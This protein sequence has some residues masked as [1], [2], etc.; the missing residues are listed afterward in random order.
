[1][2]SL[3]LR[4]LAVF[5]IAFYVL[6]CILFTADQSLI[7]VSAV[8]FSFLFIA[9]L[10]L[11]AF[12]PSTK[13]ISMKSA[14]IR[15]LIF[16]L[17]G[18][19]LSSLIMFYSFEIK[20]SKY[21]ELCDKEVEIEGSVTDV[22]W[23]GG[24]SG[25]YRVK[26][27]SIDS[28]SPFSCIITTEGGISENTRISSV[29]LFSPLENNGQFD[30]KS[31]YLSQNVYLKGESEKVFLLGEE[32]FTLSS[33]AGLINDSLSRIFYEY[34]G[35]EEGSFA[36]ALLLGNTSKL[37]DTVERDFKRL[38]IS[39]V[40]AISGMHLTVLCSFA[41]TLL[42]PLGKRASNAGC[43]VIVTFYMFITGFAPP[44]TR[45]GIVVLL[46]IFS[47]LIHKSSD[48]FT[49]LGISVFLICIADPFSAADIGLQL[50]FAALMAILL[51]SDKREELKSEKADLK[52]LPTS[53]IKI[54]K[55]FTSFLDEATLTAII[56]LFMLPIEWLYFKRLCPISPFI[57]PLFSFLGNILLWT[58][59][60]L[61]F[62][63]PAPTLSSLLAYPLKFL[64]NIIT[65]GAR[66]LSSFKWVTFS[67]NYPFALFF[68]IAIFAAICAFCITKNKK[69]LICGAVS[70]ILIF[71]FIVSGTV[72][73]FKERDTATISMLTYKSNDGLCLVNKNKAMIIDM[74]NGY[75][76]IL[77]AGST[78]LQDTQTTEIEILMLTHYHN[79]YVNTLDSFLSRNIVRNLLIPYPENDV[80][81]QL[82]K[83]CQKHGVTVKSYHPEEKILFEDITLVPWEN[84]YIKRSVQPIVRI[85]ISAK[86]KTLTYVGA[87]FSESAPNTFFDSDYIFF[88]DHG[89]LYKN[90]FSPNAKENCRIYAA[91]N[92]SSFINWSGDISIPSA[93]VLE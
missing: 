48:G 13:K 43:I 59:P 33:F 70:L 46:L 64:I 87:A 58:L 77:S 91:N 54:K 93:V 28:L 31:Y 80:A 19:S 61:L 56:I 85:D 57:S 4:P 35:N 82:E 47:S 34:L 78:V 71:A 89:P 86:G 16:F 45:S 88:G 69:R 29:V 50:S 79:S 37:P 72:F 14:A 36:A 11:R 75:S 23:D 53:V 21:M 26:V 27:D 60:I 41:D 62:L 20:L 1:M 76:G 51:L 44:V 22:I 5:T 17:A 10:V 32:E 92:A 65:K 67:L 84:T 68:A 40:L 8:I 25:I 9:T 6:S 55:F 90:K 66:W 18:C 30:E 52:A 73:N 39:H 63:S 15:T 49:N 83:L 24:F 74:G 42:R 12:I 2:K 81:V 38:G 3:I 7:L